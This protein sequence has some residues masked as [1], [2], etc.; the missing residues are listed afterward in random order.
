[1]KKPMFLRTALHRRGR[2]LMA[3]WQRLV[4]YFGDGDHQ[5]A[6]R[7]YPKLASYRIRARRI[8]LRLRT[9]NYAPR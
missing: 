8:A 2:E 9:L 6:E 1:M 3:T 5:A 7:F 4:E